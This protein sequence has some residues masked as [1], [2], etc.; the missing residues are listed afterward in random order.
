MSAAATYPS[1]TELEACAAIVYQAM[2]WSSTAFAI[3]A[4]CAI[5]VA[6]AVR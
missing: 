1:L 5:C 6:A 2:Q 4:D 3:G